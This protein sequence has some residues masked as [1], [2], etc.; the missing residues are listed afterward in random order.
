MHSSPMRRVLEFFA[1]THPEQETAVVGG[2]L[3]LD[4]Y[5]FALPR[6]SDLTRQLTVKLIGAHEDGVVE[7]LHD[8]YFGKAP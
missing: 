1:H 8:R 4:K 6:N 5:G 3:Q 2:N 7:A